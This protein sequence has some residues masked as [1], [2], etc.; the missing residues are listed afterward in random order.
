ML[1]SRNGCGFILSISEITGEPENEDDGDRDADQPKK[2]TFEHGIALPLSV[3][4]KGAAA[5]EGSRKTQLWH[6]AHVWRSGDC[7]PILVPRAGTSTAL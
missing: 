5:A 2:S 4:G 1:F 3:S 7:E 6:G